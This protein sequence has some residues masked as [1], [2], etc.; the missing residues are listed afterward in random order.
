MCC[1]TKWASQSR[2]APVRAPDRRSLH[3]A[4][5]RPGPLGTRARKTRPGHSL[6]TIGPARGRRTPL[7]RKVALARDTVWA[8]SDLPAKSAMRPHPVPTSQHM[9]PTLSFH[10]LPQSSASASQAI[11][12]SSRMTVPSQSSMM[13]SGLMSLCAMPRPWRCARASSSWN[14]IER[15]S[16]S[17][18]RPAET[19]RRDRSGIS[20]GNVWL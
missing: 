10:S 3:P 13:F 18:G 14:V 16:S 12:K 20:C 17:A 11:P 6:A 2:R 7:V 5:R 19:E 4:D 8:I 9:S 15:K 1:R